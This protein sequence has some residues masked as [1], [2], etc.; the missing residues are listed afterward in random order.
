MQTHR[1]QCYSSLESNEKCGE[2]VVTEKRCRLGV[3]ASGRGS[4]FA[5]VAKNCRREDFPVEVAVL[6][7][8]NPEAGAIAIAEEYGI[9]WRH[10][11]VGEKRGRMKP[12]SEQQIVDVL[13]EYGVELVFLAGFM[14][15]LKEPLLDRYPNKIL[16]IH[17]S[18]LPSFKGLEAQRQA[19][20]YGVKIAG[21]SVHFVDKSV[22]GGPIIL[23]AAVPVEDSDNFDSLAQRILAQEH[24]IASEA[25]KIVALG[26]YRIEG[27]RVFFEQ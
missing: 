25:I 1:A 14:R 18:L 11:D 21:C 5:A 6:V 22:D 2:E 23:Q 7:T 4:N 12:G 3:L 27:R 26:Q 20:E 24:R 16:N 15:I 13:E 9:P 10:I 17:P 8:D 19:L